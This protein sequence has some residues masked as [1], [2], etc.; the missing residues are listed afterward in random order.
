M[1]WKSTASELHDVGKDH[2]EIVSRLQ[3]AWD[4][5][6]ERAFVDV[7]IG[8]DHNN[9]GRGHQGEAFGLNGEKPAFLWETNGRG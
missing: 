9:W 8:P 3:A 7:W 6:A 1:I 4:G 5:W 2:P